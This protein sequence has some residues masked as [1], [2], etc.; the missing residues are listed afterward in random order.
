MSVLF[1]PVC[2]GYCRNVPDRDVI[3]GRCTVCGQPSE[4]A[5]LPANDTAHEIWPDSA[6]AEMERLRKQADM[7]LLA[8]TRAQERTER[9]GAEV[10]RLRAELDKKEA[11][12]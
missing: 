6:L 4:D 12:P 7:N 10:E 3:D 1:P 8:W 2:Y 9:A 5:P 11:S